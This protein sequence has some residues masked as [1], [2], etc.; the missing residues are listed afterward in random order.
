MKEE[1]VKKYRIVKR[2]NKFYPEYFFGNVSWQMM[3]SFFRSKISFSTLDEADAYLKKI[4]D[5]DL[6]DQRIIDNQEILIHYSTG[7][8]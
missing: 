7:S 5:K 8:K 4:I 6:K 2:E 1:R 3:S